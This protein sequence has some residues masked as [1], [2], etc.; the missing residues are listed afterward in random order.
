VSGQLRI[1]RWLVDPRRGLEPA[2]AYP[3]QGLAL[4]SICGV[5]YWSVKHEPASIPAA[6]CAVCREVVAGAAFRSLE[7]IAELEQT[8]PAIGRAT[9]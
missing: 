6:T 3:E 2:H 1:V 7:E 9:A 4:R 8:G 5:A